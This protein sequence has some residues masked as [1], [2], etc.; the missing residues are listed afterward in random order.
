MMKT[1]SNPRSALQTARWRSP[2]RRERGVVLIVSIVLLAIVSILAAL[3]TRNAASSENLSGNVRLTELAMQ[4]AEI[5]LRHCEQ[6]VAE[7]IAVDGGA[8]E[9][10]P[11]LGFTMGHILAVGSEAHWESA[12][13]WDTPTAPVYVFPLAQMNQPGLAATYRRSPECMAGRLQFVLPGGSISTNKLFV[14]TARGFGPEVP[15]ADPNRSRPDGSEVWL[16]SHIE[17]Q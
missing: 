3:S 4:A 5:A 6:S 9:T 1:Y 8:S 2:Q 15:A 12:S 10:Y 17:L 13:A 16:Q 7:V 14:I 11:T